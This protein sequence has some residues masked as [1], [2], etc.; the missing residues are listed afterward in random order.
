MSVQQLYFC[1]MHP[2]TVALQCTV[3]HLTC[4]SSNVIPRRRPGSTPPSSTQWRVFG[5]VAF[6][7]RWYI[8]IYSTAR[9]YIYIYWTQRRQAEACLS[10]T[11]RR[12]V[13]QN[14]RTV[15]RG[16][17]YLKIFREGRVVRNFTRLF[18]LFTAVSVSNLSTVIFVVVW[19]CSILEVMSVVSESGVE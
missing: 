4:G 16:Q 14:S 1:T 19:F 15:G 18:Y 7:M 6:L 12:A 11:A 9:I 5:S 8:Y 13:K 3:G 10:N 2:H 17:Y